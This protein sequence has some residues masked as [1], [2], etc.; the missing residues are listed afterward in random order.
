TD[1]PLASL[2]ESLNGLSE[3]ETAGEEDEQ[4]L[5]EQPGEAA[6]SLET[7]READDHS[8]EAVVAYAVSSSTLAE[9]E[10]DGDTC[11]VEVDRDAAVLPPEIVDESQPGE[12]AFERRP[13]ERIEDDEPDARP[14]D[15]DQSEAEESAAPIELVPLMTETAD[16]ASIVGQQPEVPVKTASEAQGSERRHL[17]R[18]A[19]LVS[20][21]NLGSSLLGM[22]RQIVVT[23]QGTAIASPFNAALSPVNNF[24][25]LL[26]NGST[27]GALIPVFN[28][29]AAP[30]KRQEMRRVV[31][32]VVNLILIIAVIASLG[33]LLISPWFVDT[34]VSG[35]EG[36][37][38][39][40]TLQ[41]SQIIFFSLVVLGPFAV[42]LA[43]LFS[44]KT[45]GWP[46]FA[47]AAYHA[48]IILGALAFGLIGN[49]VWGPI[50]LPIGL[51]IGAAGQ[52]VLLLPGIRSRKLYYMFVL[53]LKH[54]ALK[55]I[56][57][58]YWPIAISYV[59]S[60]ALVFLDLH[61]QSN[62]PQHAAATT[63]MA[64]AT[65]LIQFPVGLVAQALSVAVLPTLAEHAREGNTERFKETLL[66]GIRLGLLLMIPAMV[67]LLVLRTPVVYV[68]FSHHRYSLKDGDLSALALQNYA[69]Q[70]PF[71][72][73][74]QL[75][76]AA[77][78][79]RKNTK[80]PVII[81]I[82]SM[83]FYLAV[84]LPFYSTI[85]VAALAFANTVQN[86]S[87]ALIL[88]ILL[89]LSIGSL[90]IRK[91]LPAILKICLAAAA[92][93]LVAWGALALLGFVPLFALDHL[94][95]QILTVIVAGGLAVAV[96]IGG[97]LLLKVE[98]IHLVKRAVLAK[99][100]KK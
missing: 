86:S 52:I 18:S 76:I 19:A 78:Y 8:A 89:R 32:T 81:G 63:A 12:Q 3:E 26:V 54:P 60:M 93:G 92:M 82:V 35:Y 49:Q 7:E 96:Y 45:F 42:L 6:V 37:D 68:I 87:H 50:M 57:R 17:V 74:D 23:S 69:Y 95:G 55:R 21:G 46:A 83:L 51:L 39:A 72:A 94:F 85:G 58:L 22:V 31:F 61:L 70:L 2:S 15:A 28:D 43:A 90:H 30:E 13:E 67:G 73:M 34:L 25:Q 9:G 97:I 36:A 38:K 80:T 5:I 11:S 16:P 88:L 14:A 33:Y 1:K 77:F 20:I 64:T 41:F 59:F 99:L 79:A 47:T 24:Y 56:Y 84:A 98:E 27:D 48:G 4:T 65:T 75:L 53:D 44:L 62:T 29:Y 71:V 91:T 40:L 10:V 100:G 66:L